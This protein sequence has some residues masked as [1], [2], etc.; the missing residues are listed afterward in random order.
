MTY[1]WSGCDLV[2]SWCVHH[3]R[4]SCVGKLDTSWL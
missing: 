4:S 3:C 2:L 1:H